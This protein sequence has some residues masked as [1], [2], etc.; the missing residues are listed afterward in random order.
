MK[1]KL[2]FALLSCLI[3]LSFTAFAQQ[4]PPQVDFMKMRQ[5]PAT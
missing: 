1:T 4:A 5:S 2:L 3:L